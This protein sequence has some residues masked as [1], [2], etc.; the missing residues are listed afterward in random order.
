MLS[1]APHGRGLP[2]R[3]DGLLVAAARAAFCQRRKTLR[4]SLAAGLGAAK[5]PTEAAIV[6]AGLDPGARAETLALAD[7]AAL[8][9][10]LAAAGL[11]AAV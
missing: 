3:E 6:A 2:A 10:A 7:F 5:A 8:G 9:S 11:L 1:L 4:N